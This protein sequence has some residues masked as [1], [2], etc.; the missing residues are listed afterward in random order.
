MG[1][2]SRD[3]DTYRYISLIHAIPTLSREDELALASR[4][5]EHGD[6]A[7]KDRVVQANLRNVVP[8]A[9]RYGH[10]GIGVGELIAQ[11]SLALVAALDRFEPA[12]GLRFA[13]YANHWVRAE[14]LGLILQQRSMVGGGRGPLR[15]KYVFQLRREFRAQLSQLGDRDEA[16]RVI[17]ERFGKSADQIRDII[18]RIDSRDASLDATPSDGEGASL[19]DR[20]A[21]DMSVPADTKFEVDQHQALIGSAVREATADLNERER[22]IVDHR[23][24]AER[25]ARMSL[26]DIGAHFG[27]SR[28]RARQLE[29]GL[30][31]KLAKRL[32]RV[33]PTAMAA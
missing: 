31:Q 18:A 5:L 9:L 6:L 13:T 29:S 19:G 21:D 10:F 3:N 1:Q 2:H 11:G 22:F 33:A 14:I 12:R 26:V 16:A 7:A 24:M 28:E 20:I 25:E 30:K 15:A 17:G 23:L 32:K 8:H 27:V 4:Y